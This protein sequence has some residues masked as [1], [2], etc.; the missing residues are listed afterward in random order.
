MTRIVTALFSLSLIAPLAAQA[1]S[2]GNVGFAQNGRRAQIERDEHALKTLSK[3]ELPSSDAGMFIEA[4]VLM[5]VK[6]DEYVAVFALAHEGKTPA[7]CGRK[8]DE[9][10]KAFTQALKELGIEGDN[11]FVDFIAQTKTYGFEFEGNVAREK[12]VGFE[13]K[14]NVLIHYKDRLLIDR[15]VVLAS[16]LDIDDLVKVDYIVTDVGQVRERLADEAAVIVKRKAARFSKNLG[17]G[18]KLPAQVYLERSGA[19]Y[20]SEMYDS[21]TAAATEEV[22]A[23]FDRQRYTV[24]SARKGRTFYFNGLD[25]SSFDEVINPVIVEPVVQFT[26]HLKVKYTVDTTPPHAGQ[27]R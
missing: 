22:Q 14:K 17:I 4:S 9:T 2:S 8:M 7:E 25:G 27:I 1:Q 19:Y 12:H 23:P 10:V 26:M 21:Y 18:L 16:K 11:V 13:L 3:E 24:Q 5:N 20:P 6:A 15:L